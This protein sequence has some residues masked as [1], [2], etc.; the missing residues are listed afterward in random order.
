M[1]KVTKTL[2]VL[3][4]TLM[5]FSCGGGVGGGKT[6]FVKYT[7]KDGKEVSFGDNDPTYWYM[8][9]TYE[10][11]FLSTPI[12]RILFQLDDDITADNIVG[13]TIDVMITGDNDEKFDA[14]KSFKCKVEALEFVKK[15]M[16]DDKVYKLIGSFNTDEY[17]N[18]KLSLQIYI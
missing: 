2:S 3:L 6:Y 10:N 5:L 16:F 7:D 9:P 18:G 11:K 15:G 12:K 4:L 1:K 8:T 17:K 14:E 13:R